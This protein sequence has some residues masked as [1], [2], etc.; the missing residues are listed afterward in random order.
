MVPVVKFLWLFDPDAVLTLPVLTALLFAWGGSGQ[1]FW[2]SLLLPLV[3][4]LSALSLGHDWWRCALSVVSIF[5][6][7]K[8]FSYGEKAKK[9]TGR[10]Y[11]L[12]LAV[13]GFMYCVASAPF[14]SDYHGVCLLA[15]CSLGAGIIFAGITLLSQAK[16]I[17]WKI[18]EMTM[19]FLIGLG[20]FL[21]IK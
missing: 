20:A 13:V 1:H 9:K 12:W 15:I 18:V 17:T 11:P 3:I 21:L 10:F 4:G 14:I 6:S 19:G 8:V 7:L 5:L 2:R 16:K